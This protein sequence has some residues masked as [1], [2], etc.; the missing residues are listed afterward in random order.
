MYSNYFR[1][2]RLH[3]MGDSATHPLA[4]P[5]GRPTSSRFLAGLGLR[6]RCCAPD[7]RPNAR[8]GASNYFF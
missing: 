8:S 3:R 7:T 5:V 1:F 6:R 2:D 4:R